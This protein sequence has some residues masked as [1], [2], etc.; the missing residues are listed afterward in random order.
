M[1]NGQFSPSSA[2]S[3]I[4]VQ[5]CHN[6]HAQHS[7]HPCRDRS[8]PTIVLVTV[9]TR[10]GSKG[11][12]MLQRSFRTGLAAANGMCQDPLRVMKKGPLRFKPDDDSS[13]DPTGSFLRR[14]CRTREHTPGPLRFVQVRT[15]IY[16]GGSSPLHGRALVRR[17][18]QRIFDPDPDP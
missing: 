13:N 16:R 3:S 11:R 17:S 14:T 5:S 10:G 1:W 15:I 4:F 9:G 8:P 18:P 12:G 2:S 6:I 7:L